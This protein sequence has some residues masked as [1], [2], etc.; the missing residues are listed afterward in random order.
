M[1]CSD[2]WTKLFAYVCGYM[3][4]VVCLWIR[5]RM[6]TYGIQ[7]FIAPE[8]P[9]ILGFEGVSL[10]DL[11]LSDWAWLLA[12]RSR[13]PW[14]LHS[15]TEIRVHTTVLGFSVWLLRMEICS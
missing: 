8:E 7:R 6:W 2:N 5:I 1:L 14:C 11:K 3:L 12:S 15:S 10:A 4:L 13:G 9:C